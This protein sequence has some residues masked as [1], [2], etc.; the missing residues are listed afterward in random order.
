MVFFKK[1]VKYFFYKFLGIFPSSGV[2]ILTYHSVGDDEEFFNVKTAL[3]EKQMEYLKVNNFNVIKLNDL[4]RTDNLK[5]LK[6]TVI[7][8]F[9]DGYKN[10]YLNAFPI[11]KK[12]DLPA[13]VFINTASLGKNI[14]AR[15]GTN[16]EILSK[17]EIKEMYKSNLIEFGSHC[18]NH[19]KLTDLKNDRVEEEFVMSKKIIFD[20]LGVYPKSLAYPFGNFDERIKR[21]A[22]KFFSIVVTVE[23]GKEKKFDLLNLKRNSVDSMVSMDE[24]KNIVKIGKI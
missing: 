14:I 24:F 2:V 9:D 1:I 13:T 11:L 17:E 15:R 16:M 7:I 12:Y 8:T 19:P 10:N 5:K 4:S 21:M 18:H 23:K 22:G 3:F 20:L 6:K